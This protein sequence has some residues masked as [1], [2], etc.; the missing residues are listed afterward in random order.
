MWRSLWESIVKL[1][2]K[3]SRRK[4]FLSRRSG[5]SE[6]IGKVF[7]TEEREL[8]DLMEFLLEQ[9]DWILC[10]VNWRFVQAIEKIC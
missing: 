8:L 7:Y 10:R 4:L 5:T 6:T 1:F 9:I 3:L 2:A